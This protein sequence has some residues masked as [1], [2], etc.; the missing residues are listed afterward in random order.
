[1]VGLVV[2]AEVDI[3]EALEE[4]EEEL[5]TGVMEDVG[6]VRILGGAV[7]ELFIDGIPELAPLGTPVIKDGG[8]VIELF[9]SGM[10]ELGP[11][12][13]PVINDGGRVTELFTDRK[14]ELGPLETPVTSDGKTVTVTDVTPDVTISDI[15]SST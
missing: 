1:M 5:D 13:I 12:G 2:V 6:F 3:E 7:K 9:T 8:R 15:V 4:A 11:L 14:P 10:P